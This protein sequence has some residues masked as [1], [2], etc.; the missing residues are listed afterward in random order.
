MNLSSLSSSLAGNLAASL[1]MHWGI[2]GLLPMYKGE[3]PK[4]YLMIISGWLNGDELFQVI[5]SEGRLYTS[6]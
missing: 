4:V 6:L 3:E 1:M 5:F 2:V